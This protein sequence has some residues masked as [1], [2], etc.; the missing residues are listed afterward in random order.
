MFCSHCGKQVESGKFCPYC[1]NPLVPTVTQT[2]PVQQYPT[3]APPYTQPVFGSPSSSR[4]YDTIRSL[5]ASPLFLV[6]AIAFTLTIVASLIFSQ[7]TGTY[8]SEAFQDL[9]QTML[10]AGLD[11]QEIPGQL[12]NAAR[13]TG[14]LGTAISMLPT[15]LIAA[16]IWMVYAAAKNRSKPMSADGLT[17]LRVMQIIELVFLCFGA[18]MMILV[19]VMVMALAANYS[20]GGSRGEEILSHTAPIIAIILVLALAIIVVAI[21]YMAKLIKTIKT[22]RDTVTTGVPSDKVSGFVAVILIIGAVIEILTG[23]SVLGFGGWPATVLQLLNATCGIC[24][25]ILILR[26]KK[27]MRELMQGSVYAPM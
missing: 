9:Q 27:A 26:Y 19:F 13:G 4:V 7:F 12:E 15:I 11:V 10:D 1:G 20:S 17:L 18:F 8:I 14:I 5:A 25:G 24:F 2:E 22:M 3:Y 21:V 23:L 16:G 6:A